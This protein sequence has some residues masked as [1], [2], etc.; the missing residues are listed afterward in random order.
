MDGG[1]S[2]VK[3]VRLRR[4]VHILYCKVHTVHV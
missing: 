3:L 2:T 4:S 1:V